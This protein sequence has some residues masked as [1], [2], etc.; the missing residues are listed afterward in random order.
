MGE[1]VRFLILVPFLW[2]LDSSYPSGAGVF[3]CSRLK[4]CGG[5]SSGV[6]WVDGPLTMS[7][8]LALGFALGFAFGLGPSS[9]AGISP[10]DRALLAV[11]AFDSAFAFAF[12]LPLGGSVEDAGC[13]SPGASSGF[14]VVRWGSRA[15]R[16]LASLYCCR[17]MGPDDGPPC[18]GSSSW[19]STG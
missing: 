13:V 1:I 16:P 17:R 9:G 3:E 2:S 10:L 5:L 15:N 14:H 12:G 6:Y 18:G 19:C 7:D 8:D 11:L 4:G